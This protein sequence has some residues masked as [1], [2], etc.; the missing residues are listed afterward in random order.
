[1]N[2]KYLFTIFIILLLISGFFVLT[3]NKPGQLSGSTISFLD[4]QSNI[5][6]NKYKKAIDR[7]DFVFPDDHGA[8]PEYLTEWWYYTGNIFTDDG[9][10]FGYQL[11]FFRRAISDQFDDLSASNWASNQIYLAHFAVTDTASN[12]HY[13]FDHISR[14]SAGLAG[15]SVNPLFSIWL[16]DW[17]IVQLSDNVF[18]MNA[19]FDNVE[20]NLILTDVKGIIFHGDDGLSQKGSEIGNAS[21]YFSQTRMGTTGRIRISDEEF[22]VNGFSWMD[23]EF[24]TSTLGSNQIGWDWFSIQLDKQTEIM[25]FQIRQEDGS[26]SDFSSG[27]IIFKDGNTEN[28]EVN[29]FEIEVLDTWQTSDQITYPNKW[30]I[31]IEQI[32]LKMEITPVMNDQEM[33]LFFRYW[34]GAVRINGT[35]NGEEISG[36][37]YVELTGYA[38]SMQGVF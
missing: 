23:H 9:R 13:V 20:I 10:H 15:T 36:Y 32:N 35:L 25:L 30:K 38:Q 28:L 27:T 5:K 12:Q 22:D 4:D 3:I 34:E 1:M 29:D 37:G 8:H 11:T 21:Y 19:G 7:M 18:Q 26:F 16:K 6:E 17:E 31:N 2:K 14:G 24:G 33:N